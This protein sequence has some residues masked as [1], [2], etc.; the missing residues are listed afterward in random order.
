MEDRFRFRS[1]G[2][3]SAVG[4]FPSGLV[5]IEKD[6]KQKRENFQANTS[7]MSDEILLFAKREAQRIRQ[8]EKMKAQAPA[9]A[10]RPKSA[11]Y[12]NSRIG[13]SRPSIS[14]TRA[15]A[16]QAR[17]STAQ[18]S[19][20]KSSISRLSFKASES[21]TG[22]GAQLTHLRQEIEEMADRLAEPVPSDLEDV[23]TEFDDESNRWFAREFYA[24]RHECSLIKKMRDHN[25]QR[26]GVVKLHRT[27]LRLVQVA[28]SRPILRVLNPHIYGQLSDLV[29]ELVDLSD[30]LDLPL[31][32]PEPILNA[33]ERAVYFPPRRSVSRRGSIAPS[34]IAE[35]IAPRNRKSVSRR[36]P[37]KARISVK[38]QKRTTEIYSGSEP[39]RRRST[40][41]SASTQ[42]RRPIA[43]KKTKSILKTNKSKS[44]ARLSFAGEEGMSGGVGERE[45]TIVGRLVDIDS[46]DEPIGARSKA[47][48]GPKI[49]NQTK[50][51]DNNAQPDIHTP[52]GQTIKIQVEGASQT[53]L[54]EKTENLKRSQDDRP[55]EKALR[56]I[57][58]DKT[59]QNIFARL[60]KIEREEN[61]VR[62]RLARLSQESWKL[63]KAIKAPEKHSCSEISIPKK[64]LNRENHQKDAF[65]FRLLQS[66][67]QQ[68]G[69]FRKNEE[70]EK[71]KRP[72][73]KSSQITNAIAEEVMNEIIEDVMTETEDAIGGF[74]EEIYASELSGLG[75]MSA[76]STI[77]S[78]SVQSSSINSS[79]TAAQDSSDAT[80]L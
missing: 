77:L 31:W 48:A 18:K 30:S 79:L 49:E 32:D 68:S 38:S 78:S 57:L 35:A 21:D 15:P 63:E 43:P 44:S 71:N 25:R 17:S 24:V 50:P 26:V 27:A 56:S 67:I 6:Q 70:T 74:V 80:N 9:P 5:L 69:D 47:G 45:A 76:I 4:S 12:S 59:V 34:D 60:D 72:L 3:T 2:L 29:Q 20:P 14:V 66:A 53:D 64:Y 39:P 19:R 28:A 22:V 36:K 7:V 52:A 37:E 23:D 41:K 10:A 16:R 8:I 1:G 75:P 13:E 40:T 33:L 46:L 42:N 54:G 51:K 61:E 65:E 62:D 73:N 55:N 58:P 11:S